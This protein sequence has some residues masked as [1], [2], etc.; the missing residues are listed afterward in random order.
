MNVEYKDG[1]LIITV[2]YTEGNSYPLSSTKKSRMV[3]TS[4]GFQTV[5]GTKGLKYSLNVIEV[6]P[7]GER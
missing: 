5:D 1:N 6:V 4:G 3:A 2:P 7:K